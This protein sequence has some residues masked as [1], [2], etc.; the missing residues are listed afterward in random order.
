MK[1]AFTFGMCRVKYAYGKKE[2][3]VGFLKLHGVATAI[4]LDIY[5]ETITA[6]VRRWHLRNLGALAPVSL[7]G[8][9]SGSEPRKKEAREI[10]KGAI[11]SVRCRGP[12]RRIAA[13]SKR[14]EP[15]NPLAR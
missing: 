6:R 14:A 8:R 1:L 5:G 15:F 9:A 7:V 3:E 4:W 10:E 12:G 11:S 2:K 13:E